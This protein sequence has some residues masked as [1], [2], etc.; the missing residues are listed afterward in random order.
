MKMISMLY[1]I[2]IERY[3]DTALGETLHDIKL[4]ADKMHGKWLWQFFCTCLFSIIMSGFLMQF[5]SGIFHNDGSI[6]LS[7]IPVLAFGKGI[8]LTILIFLI[9]NYMCYLFRKSFAKEYTYVE[10]RNFRISNEGTYGTASEMQKPERDSVFYIAP[11]ED[12][13]WT[14]LGKDMTDNKL[15][16]SLKAKQDEKQGIKTLSTVNPH[17]CVVGTSMSGKSY[18]VIIPTIMQAIR[19]GE[20]VITTSP[21]GELFQNLYAVAKKHGYTVKVLNLNPDQLANSDCVHY[22]KYAIKNPED[23]NECIKDVFSFARTIIDN[24]RTEGEK[25]EKF[26]ED[27]TLSLLQSIILW[28]VLSPDIPESERTLGNIYMKLSEWGV[29]GVLAAHGHLPSNH[30]AK[31]SFRTFMDSPDSVRQSAVSGLLL[32]LQIL[33]APGVRRITDRE[34]MSL[35]APGEEKCLYFIGMSADEDTLRF[36]VALYFTIQ[37]QALTKLA[38]SKYGRDGEKLPVPVNFILDEFA[39]CGIIP[40]MTRKLATVRSYNISVLLALQDIPQVMKLYP[41]NFEWQTILSQCSTHIVLKT[42]DPTT[43]E[44]YS[45]KSGIST[46]VS[47]NDRYLEGKADLVKM[48][49]TT[50][51]TES[52]N[53]RPALTTD[54]V[55][56]LK[57]DELYV[58][59]SGYNYIKLRKF[60]KHEHPFFEEIEEKYILDYHPDDDPDGQQNSSGVKK[61]SGIKSDNFSSV[62]KDN[63][64]DVKKDSSSEGPAGNSKPTQANRYKPISKSAKKDNSSESI[65]KSGLQPTNVSETERTET[66]KDS[67]CNTASDTQDTSVSPSS[68]KNDTPATAP[69]HAPRKAP[70]NAGGGFVFRHS[71]KAT[72][73][74][75]NQPVSTDKLTAETDR[76]ICQEENRTPE[77]SDKPEP[78]EKVD[79]ST[80]TVLE[81]QEQEG[82]T[83]TN[84]S[85]TVHREPR[86][87]NS[88]DHS[89]EVHREPLRNQNLGA[90]KRTTVL[91]VSTKPVFTFDGGGADAQAQLKKEEKKEV[92]KQVFENAHFR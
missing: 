37:F 75:E 23:Q 5:I 86:P 24:T 13:E 18:S 50:Y 53:K 77:N 22:L 74:N 10:D 82:T 6:I 62:K 49:P 36:L 70:V 51:K 2:I 65:A 17:I 67:N 33:G 90:H 21:K 83:N 76:T 91:P 15:L 88:S 38:K 44:Y 43:E 84:V 26:F 40:G 57:P 42:N 48:H 4:D 27:S 31:R 73:H 45:K 85:K 61:D 81:K 87:A 7:K 55:N 78:V 59:I 9:S 14:I 58:F 69:Q 25:V 19:R 72:I 71:V 54:E 30:P 47:K 80:S 89:N 68:A 39:T 60:G 92:E 11:I 79:V 12:N 66:I 34:S 35:T 41:Q 29:S 56:R 64:S 16:Y 63:F 8:L 1:K 3:G 32:K 46:V 52:T 28:M 20:S